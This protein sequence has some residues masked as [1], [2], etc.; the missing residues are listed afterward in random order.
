[1]PLTELQLTTVR[2]LFERVLRFPSTFDAAERE[3]L[4]VI[5]PFLAL[6]KRHLSPSAAD[7]LRYFFTIDLARARLEERTVAHAD[8]LFKQFLEAHGTEEDADG[9]QDC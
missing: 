8:V 9:Q 3:Y 6:H 4:A 2:S 7:T 1:M 5:V